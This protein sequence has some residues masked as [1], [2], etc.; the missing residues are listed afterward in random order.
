[1]TRST[2]IP[3]GEGEIV[4]EEQNIFKMVANHRACDAF[5]KVLKEMI[6]TSKELFRN[7]GA[8]RIADAP[9][10]TSR[11]AFSDGRGGA[12]L[13]SKPD[14]AKAGTR[15]KLPAKLIQAVGSILNLDGCLET[16]VKGYVTGSLLE[17]LQMLT[18]GQKMYLLA[19][20]ELTSWFEGVFAQG[21]QPVP[22]P[23]KGCYSFALLEEEFTVEEETKL[24]PEATAA[25]QAQLAQMDAAAPEQ[26]ADP[27]IYEAVKALVE[28]A[29]KSAPVNVR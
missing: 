15:K 2:V 12:V 28:G 18:K 27:K 4:V 20:P 8:R 1:M 10:G 3:D 9:P 17:L 29:V 24:T 19:G 21:N 25:F 14:L 7:E 5:S 13:I 6:D 16:I 23:D 26:L 22:G 11:I